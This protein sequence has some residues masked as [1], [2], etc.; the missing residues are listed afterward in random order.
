MTRPARTSFQQEYNDDMTTNCQL[1]STC[2]ESCS[3]SSD[4]GVVV[5]SS[6]SQRPSCLKPSSSSS[7]S[8]QAHPSIPRPLL[9]QYFNNK[10]VKALNYGDY[11]KATNLFVQAIKTF[12]D[13]GM[14]NHCSCQHCT[15]SS[16]VR[17]SLEQDSKPK[18]YDTSKDHYVH[19]RGIEV[20]PG[21]M[22]HKMGDAL[23]QI[24]TL[25]L[26]IAKHLICLECPLSDHRAQAK[27]YQ[28]A[29]SLYEMA[30]KWHVGDGNTDQ[31]TVNISVF[32][33]IVNNLSQIHRKAN[34]QAKL[35]MCRRHL[36][37]ALMTLLTTQE[38]EMYQVL[39]L[40]GFVCTA[41]VKTS[42][43][44]AA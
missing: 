34:N 27:R 29:A 43:A 28:K 19:R 25:N 5:Q 4:T 21:A 1:H 9:A 30:F 17:Y 36:Q 42:C 24:T 15:V 2:D 32:L 35:F 14:D 31:N 38:T 40:D 22:G 23:L 6:I 18:I 20:H 13:D 11:R 12:N 16:S 33:I 44:S 26:A 8:A 10:G 39:H 7:R 41:F 3:Q 37:S